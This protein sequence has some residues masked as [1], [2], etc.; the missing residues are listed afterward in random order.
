MK[1]PGRG[2]PGHS[3]EPRYRKTLPKGVD[4]Y[5]LQSVSVLVRAQ[6]LPD[7]PWKPRHGRGFGADGF[8]GFVLRRKNAL[9]LLGLH[10]NNWPTTSAPASTVASTSRES[11]PSHAGLLWEPQGLVQ[12]RVVEDIPEPIYGF[13]MRPRLIAEY[14]PDLSQ[15]KRENCVAAAL[16]R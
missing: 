12:M 5:G 1:S 16:Q 10:T 14:A 9:Q 13:A 11:T 2:M 6:R 8:D 7:R 4:T 15:R 3:E